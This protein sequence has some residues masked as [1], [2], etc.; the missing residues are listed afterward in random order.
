MEGMDGYDTTR[1]IRQSTDIGSNRTVP[2]IAMTAHVMQ[3]D[4]EK[5]IAAGMD[6]FVS[7]PIEFNILSQTVAEWLPKH[8][9]QPDS[10]KALG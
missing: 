1:K 5:C 9:S 7:K 2:I 6:D 3:S 8:A 10:G 4:R